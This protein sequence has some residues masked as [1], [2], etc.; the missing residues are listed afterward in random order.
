MCGT[1]QQKVNAF[2]TDVVVWLFLE[3]FSR[4]QSDIPFTKV[5]YFNTMKPL[6]LRYFWLYGVMI[7]GGMIN[8]T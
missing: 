7:V 8:Y 5:A 4:V 1:Q 2:I 3:N 6:K